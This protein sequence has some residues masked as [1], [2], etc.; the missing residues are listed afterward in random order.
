MATAYVTDRMCYTTS[1]VNIR[2]TYTLSGRCL[3]KMFLLPHP[4]HPRI[5]V[6]NITVQKGENI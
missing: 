2:Q 5:G 1:I 4:T 3:D 6:Y